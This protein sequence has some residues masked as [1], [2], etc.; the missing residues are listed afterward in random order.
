MRLSHNVVV[1][2]R[3]SPSMDHRTLAGAAVTVLVYSE[4]VEYVY[5]TLLVLAS[6]LITWFAVYVVYRAVS[7]DS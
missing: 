3:L 2:K 4:R 5:T 6:L 1:R 7:N